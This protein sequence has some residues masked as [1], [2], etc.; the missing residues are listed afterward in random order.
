MTTFIYSHFNKSVDDRLLLVL[1]DKMEIIN[2]HPEKSQRVP[3]PGF[4]IEFLFP[5]DLV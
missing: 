3:R 2:P 1:T 4:D 5:N